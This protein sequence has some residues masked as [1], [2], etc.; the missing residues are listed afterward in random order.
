[1]YWARQRQWAHEQL[2]L[3]VNA[4]YHGVMEFEVKRWMYLILTD[5][6]NAYYSLQDMISK[7]MCTLAWNQ[8]DASEANLQHATDLLTQVSPCGPITNLIPALW[9][10]IPEQINPWKIKERKRHDG[11][12]SWWL[13]RYNQVRA[14][15]NAGLRQ[16]SWAQNY[17]DREKQQKLSGDKEAACCIGMTCLI[18]VST[19]VGTLNFFILAMVHNPEWMKKCQQ[20]LD[21]VCG[22]RMPTTSDIE[23]LP[24]LRA[25]IK[26]TMRWKPIFPT[27]VPHATEEDQVYRDWCIPKDTIIFPLE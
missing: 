20:E 15:V 19:V 17:I 22:R 10:Y 21:R 6:G 4:N 8:P 7:I 3:S 11:H 14:N 9:T 12:I 26:E 25:C 16:P 24:I 5:T 23:H 1:V 18:G 13:E 27:G 2:T